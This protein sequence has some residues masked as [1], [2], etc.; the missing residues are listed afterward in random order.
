MAVG[1]GVVVGVLVTLGDGITLGDGLVQ[2]L[3]R[4][5][6]LLQSVLWSLLVARAVPP[7]ANTARAMKIRRYMLV[8]F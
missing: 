5:N 2:R 4:M 3:R 1:L 8:P 7:I 6:E